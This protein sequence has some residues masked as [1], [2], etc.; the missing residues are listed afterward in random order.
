[1]GIV[2][3]LAQTGA[4]KIPVCESYAINKSHVCDTVVK[5]SCQVKLLSTGVVTPV[6]A[7]T[8][9][10]YGMVVVGNKVVDT[11]VTVQTNFKAIVVGTAAGTIA[12]AAKVAA[13]SYSGST[14]KVTYGAAISTNWEVGVA[15]SASTV[16]LDITVGLYRVARLVP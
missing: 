5:K 2:E 3:T 7:Q 16:G 1:M 6:T 11:Y 15:L 10:V 13:A 4:T 8:D 12:I 14:E 9:V